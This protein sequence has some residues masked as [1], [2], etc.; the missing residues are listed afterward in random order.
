MAASI[1]LADEEAIAIGIVDPKLASRHVKAGND[2]E[3]GGTIGRR[4]LDSLRR[5]RSGVRDALL[6]QM[7]SQGLDIE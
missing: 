7:S 3:N 5:W 1:Q 4:R 6:E 2:L